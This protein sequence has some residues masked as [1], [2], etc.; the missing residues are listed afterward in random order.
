MSFTATRR[1][2][3]TRAEERPRLLPARRGGQALAVLTLLA[4]VAYLTWRWGFTLSPDLLWI[5]LP[6]VLAETYAL[7]VTALQVFTCWRLT[8]RDP[9]PPIPGASVAVLVATYD[10]PADVLRPTVVSALDIRHDGPLSVWVLDDGGRPWV[11]AMCAE[12]GAR[13]LCRPA[14]RRHAK[15]GNL[16]HALEHVEAEFLVTLDADHV[17]R[18]ELLERTLGH[19]RDERLAVV[20]GP[21]VFFNRGFQH[22]GREDRPLRNEQSLFYDVICRGKDRDDAAFWCGCPSVLRRSALVDVG[23]VATATVTEDAHTT[24]RLHRAGWRSAYHDEVLAVGLAPEEIGA[25]LV[26]RGRWARGTLQMMRLDFPLAGR[27]LTWRQRVHY[28]SSGLH[29]LDGLARLVTLLVPPVVLLSGVVPIS[30]PPALYALLFLPPFVL[31][32]LATRAIT[33]GRSGLI[34]PELYGIVRMG[35]YLR[36]LWAL[37]RPRALGFQVTPKGARAAERGA[38]SCLRLPIALAALSLGAVA[39][40]AAA[41][42]LGLPGRLPAGAYAVTVAWALVNAGFIGWTVWWSGGVR[43]RRR[44]HRFPVAVQASFTARE[45][46]PPLVSASVVDLSQHGLSMRTSSRLAVGE[47]L[48]IV[49]LLDDGPATIV[50]RVVTLDAE[51]DSAEPG[52]RAGLGFEDPGDAVRDAISRWCFRHPFGPVR[53]RLDAEVA[54]EPA[55]PAA[56]P[57]PPRARAAAP[58]E[59]GT[60]SA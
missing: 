26:Q 3:G 28:L 13:Y 50:G 6:L 15:A 23:G 27:G 31:T 12:L 24:L 2:A 16:N 34:Q 45:D 10:E 56:R 51:P 43:H 21:Q 58:G 20:Q 38:S 55:R 17:P 32:P 7:L 59:V 44:S 5:G 29:F 47:R 42:V 9:G 4:G 22:F 30:A 40:Q 18:P 1:E 14:P 41:Q 49:L 46:E 11:E 8:D 57:Q 25:F 54:R 36:A 33:H 53:G 52:W 19:F 48:R 37:A 35:T 39:S 60:P